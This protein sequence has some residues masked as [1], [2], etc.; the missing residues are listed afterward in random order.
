MKPD[1]T[2]KK[3]MIVAALLVL[4]AC[5]GGDSGTSGS[6]STNSAPVA[7]A[8]MDQSVNEQINVTLDGSASSD[9][10]GD[11]LTY[12]W[13]QTGG[14]SVT[15]V[16]NS[17]AMA[18]FD[19]P[20]VGIG[21]ST[22]LT[23]QLRVADP[24]GASNT[25]TIDV[26]VNGVSNSDPVVSAGADQSVTALATV[27]LSGTASDTDIGDSL[28]YTW[29]QMSGTNVTI[30]NGDTADASFEAPA[31]GAGGETLTFQL[32]V[33]DGTAT[34]TDLV[35]VVV[36]ETPVAVTV[37]GKVFY[38]F[39]P[40]NAQCRGL[41]FAA[42]QTRPIRAATVQLIDAGSGNVLDTTIAA[43]NGDYSFNNV[44]GN[45]D[46]RL[47]VRAELKRSGAPGWDVDVR[48][49]I[50]DP[51]NP[52][53]LASRPLYV[54]D[55][56]DFNTGG[57]DVSRDFTATTG[58]D[59]SAYTGTRAA[60]PFAIL[61]AIYSGMQLVLT[62]D[63]S[64]I[65]EP[66]DAFWSVNNTL[67]SPTDIDAGEL[68]TS[69]YRSD[70][71]S[72]FLLGDAN[73]DTEEFDDHVSIHEWGHYFEDVFSRSDSIGGP[74]S[75]GQSIDA[76]LAFGEGWATA[77]AAMAL[78]EPQYCD[79]GAVGTTAGFGIDIETNNSGAQ[80]WFNEMSV[81]TFLYDLWDTNVDGTDGSSIGFGPIFDTMAGPQRNTSALTSM[82]SFAT[83]LRSQLNPAQQAFVDSQ[84]IRENIETVGIDIWG[85][86]QGS[87]M[88]SPNQARD[89]LPLYTTLP[90]DG[91][92]INICANSDYDSGR[93][94]NKLAEYRY[95]TFTTT[96]P[97]SYTVTITTTTATPPT[98]DPP[99]TPPDAIRDQSDPDMFIYRRGAIVAVGNGAAENS[100][101][102]V[103]QVLPADTYVADLQEWRYEDTEASSDFPEQICFDVSMSP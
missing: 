55:S 81:A 52:L 6:G 68:A 45:L 33:N 71:D 60:A 75:I 76:R 63:A 4:S 56:A 22:T 102:F 91:T 39:V 59:G 73:V 83:E 23:F 19:A 42:T 11:N 103:T 88:T 7:N 3:A 72:L 92:V 12:T 1:F 44:A 17:S 37:S 26:V 10:D 24:S 98:S 25:N 2:Y 58:W 90:I 99:P 65:F 29:T 96:S 30:A 54:V 89:V 15:L 40:P 18:S 77:F 94:G 61:D 31:V 46:V 43:D 84:L 82:F 35:D 27:N 66:M 53:P 87:I 16:N 20:D 62:A 86:S 70:L 57:A 85:S 69:F 67:T 95:L 49:N 13:T 93:D 32:A 47:R 34:I 97:A 36:N 41:D 64:A 48:D 101:I 38:E 9:P 28:V 21:S 8:G 51:L 50:D 78:N 5:G 100:E 80:G 74:H 14:A 79:T